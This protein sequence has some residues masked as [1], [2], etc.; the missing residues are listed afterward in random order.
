MPDDEI[1]RP[2]T[3]LLTEGAT[4][5][6]SDRARRISSL[7][8][9][10]DDL[11]QEQN[12]KRL[13][14][15]NEIDTLTKQQQKAAAQL[16]VEYGDMTAETAKG[17]NNVLKG[18]GRT[19][20]SLATGVKT[21]T[22]DTSKATSQAIGQYGKAISEDISINKTNT[23]A[24]ALSRATPLFGYFAAKFMETDVFQG[25]AR[26]IR[27]KVGSAMTEGLS[28][29]GS[30]IA[31]IFRKGKA[32]VKE[33]REK[34]PAT[35][36]DLESLQRTIEGTAPK[37]QEGGYIKRGGMIE[38]HAAEVVTPI[39]KLLKQIDEAKA[40]EISRK[41][42]K[43]LSLMSQNLIRL[44]TV[45]V[46]RKEAERGI[47]GT[48][49][50][51]FQK[52]RDT[53][54]ESHQ[55]RLLKAILEL[56]VG[57][58][59]MTSRMRIAWQR[60]LLQHPTFRN[61]LLFSDLMK[62]AIVTPIKF[63]FGVRGGY[64]GDVRGATRTHNVF[65]KVSNLLALLYSNLMPK[66]DNLVIYTKA[67]AEALVG[68]E[69]SPTTQVT[70]T[71][72]DKIREMMTSR[73]IIPLQEKIFEG[74]VSKL[75]LSKEALASAGVTTVGGLARPGKIMGA[76][77]VSRENIFGALFESKRFH[78]F[79]QDITKLREMKE[80][81]EEREG[82]HSLSMAENISKTAEFS[83]QGVE[84]SEDQAT[85]SLTLGEKA[86]KFAK[87]QLGMTKRMGARLKK[88]GSKVWDWVLIAFGFLRT[89]VGGPIKKI[90][91][92]LVSIGGVITGWLGK[93]MFAGLGMAGRGAKG[94]QA[95]AGAARAAG[96]AGSARMAATG[97]GRVGAF[98]GKVAGVAAGGILGTGMGL[99]DMVRA[100]R[101]PEGFVG[102]IFTR[103]LAGFLGGTDTGVAGAKRGAL[104]GAA[105][106]AAA[107]AFLGPGALLGGAIG[108]AAGAM[109]GFVG[110]KK[111]S[112][113]ISKTIGVIKDYVTGA[114]NIVMFPF[115]MLKEGLKSAWVLLKWGFKMTLGKAY[116]SFKEWWQKPGILQGIMGFF[117]NIFG[118][119][120]DY[121]KKPFIWLREKIKTI[122]GDEM[123]DKINKVVKTII[124]SF[125]FPLIGIQKAFTYLKNTF[126]EKI[127]G[128]PVIG[129]IFTGLIT[130][131]KDIHE[132][133]MA[134][135]LEK[136]LQELEGSPREVGR[137]AAEGPSITAREAARIA[138]EHEARRK[139]YDALGKR[140]GDKVDKG[141]DQTTAAVTHNT[142]MMTSTN[143]NQSN[144]YGRQAGYEGG[145]FGSG[146]N[147]AYDV[148]NCNI[149]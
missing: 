10:T 68:E 7:H 23:I 85:K 28:K 133:N 48:F 84:Q 144:S 50:E 21:I 112:E 102:G 93:K 2:G 75:G 111:M 30:G 99:F 53:K 143:T 35:V 86:N 71:M 149:R 70:Y 141:A 139:G 138:T 24:M 83:E 8:R 145:G 26:K 13:Q 76:M 87:E 106:G 121:I 74:V 59:G 60:T 5:M 56:K 129:K 41:L 32:V 62:S 49:I 95:G 11:V 122:L 15:S 64:A 147:F 6:A 54:Q 135:K 148:T 18:L 9:S 96:W 63:L 17:Y 90:V 79:R 27:D 34:E 126:I 137:L 29:A 39:D 136:S 134:A 73:S 130:A 4:T 46:E 12:R 14:I 124:Y 20:E 57:L 88:M 115:K 101:D 40:T 120:I 140:V 89:F 97:I 77:G 69:I 37:L 55:K 16:K 33:E 82:P 113:G 47:V 109:L 38:V 44:E 3:D 127:S 92:T 78:E 65:L 94:V 100:I 51:E 52:A 105:L 119:I 118:T 131:V 66:V 19:I 107:T 80:A 116:D 110:G 58:I 45:V 42:D 31:N 123:W 142:N 98:A 132:G 104:K 72:F 1:M 36:S 61:I 67:A 117:S 128:L 125:M 114:W 91:T 108:A 22:I 43:T 146:G 103:G 25:A 81:Q